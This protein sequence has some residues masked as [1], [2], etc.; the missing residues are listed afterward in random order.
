LLLVVGVGFI[1]WGFAIRQRYHRFIGYVAPSV[2]SHQASNQ[3]LQPTA[4]RSDD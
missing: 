4:G 1:A 3:P 2:L